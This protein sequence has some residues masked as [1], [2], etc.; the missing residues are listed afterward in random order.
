[1]VLPYRL[2]GQF[3]CNLVLAGITFT[4]TT[5]AVLLVYWI[6]LGYNSISSSP[7]CLYIQP[8]YSLYIQLIK[9]ERKRSSSSIVRST[10]LPTATVPA[11]IVELRWPK[12][13]QRWSPYQYR[14]EK[15]THVL[16]F[17]WLSWLAVLLVRWQDG[18]KARWQPYSS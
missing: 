5:F 7:H 9:N 12:G 13:P 17:S 2:D 15:E 8:I 3:T 4:I 6:F 16:I 10:Q 14:K 18:R 1:M 11:L